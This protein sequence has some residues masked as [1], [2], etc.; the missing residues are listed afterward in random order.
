M[1]HEF[2]AALCLVLVF[3]GLFLFAAPHA[4]QRMAEQMRQLEPRHLRMI[5]GVMVGVGVL[6]LK[7]VM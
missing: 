4:W 6:A 3:E 2:A 5:G 7:L 1:R